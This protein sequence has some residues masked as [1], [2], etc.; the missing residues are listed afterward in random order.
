LEYLGHVIDGG[1]LKVEP[2]KIEAIGKWPNPINVIE[3]RSVIGE[4]WI[5]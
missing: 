5:T 3:V 1:G 4:M 2:Y